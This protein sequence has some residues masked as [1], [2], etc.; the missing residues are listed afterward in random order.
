MLGGGGGACD[1][2][3]QAVDRPQ[4]GE[5]AGGFRP[6]AQPTQALAFLLVSK[7]SSAQLV[8]VPSQVH[9]QSTQD[10]CHVLMCTHHVHIHT[11]LSQMDQLA[12]P[13]QVQKVK[14]RENRISR[15]WQHS[16]SHTVLH[17]HHPSNFRNKRSVTELAM[18]DIVIFPGEQN[19]QIYI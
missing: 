10:A 11:P 15:S 9:T 2:G 8:R 7:L 4:P 14:E 16:L 13:G 5:E 18:P 6:R 12:W 3:A 1:P 19:Q 17:A